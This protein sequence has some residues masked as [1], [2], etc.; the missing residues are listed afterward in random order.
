MRRIAW[1]RLW[2]LALAAGLLVHAMLRAAAH[3]WLGEV[4]VIMETAGALLLIRSRTR[5][6][7]VMIGAGAAAVAT[8]IA[9]LSAELDAVLAPTLLLAALL[10]LGRRMDQDRSG[11]PFRIPSSLRR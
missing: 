2:A 1:T 9:L 7:G 11:R 5:A 8:G 4:V 3:A 10:L 6:I